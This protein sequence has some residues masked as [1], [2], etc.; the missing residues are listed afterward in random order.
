MKD[1]VFVP[2]FGNRPRNLVGRE[3]VL[4]FLRRVFRAFPEAGSRRRLYWGR[5]G[6][7]KRYCFWNL[8]KW[9]SPKG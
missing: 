2:A 5:E 6:Q 4:H 9:P 1:T 7:A 8:L 3:D